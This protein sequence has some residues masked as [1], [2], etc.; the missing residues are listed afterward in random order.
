[1]TVDTVEAL[2]FS[3]FLADEA[4]PIARRHFRHE[5]VVDNKPDR[6]PVTVADREIEAHLRS[7]IRAR[8]PGHGILGEEQGRYATQSEYVWVL[9]PI[10]GTKSFIS[11]V[12]LFGTLIALLHW[13]KPI[14]GVVDHPVLN[15]RWVGRPGQGASYN[16]EPCRTSGCQQLANAIVMT[17]SPDSYGPE[18][19]ARFSRAS[20]KARLRRFGGDCYSYALL[21]SGHVDAVFGA[22]LEPYDFMPMVALVEA[23]GG[24]ITGWQGETL[25]IDH[26]DG[27]VVVSASAALHAELLNQLNA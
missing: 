3:N 13:G 18:D 2:A 21:A 6:S 9:D 22:G 10:D 24:M 1:M 17:T 4:G 14:L 15:E 19:Y 25:S 20:L 16:G 27:R 7:L 26:H 12:P 23:A 8:F 5:M 11:G